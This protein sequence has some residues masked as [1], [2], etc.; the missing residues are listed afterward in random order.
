MKTTQKINEA[1]IR[2]ILENESK[3]DAIRRIAEAM[4]NRDNII[5]ALKK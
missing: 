1:F 2:S 4:T 3:E 5:V